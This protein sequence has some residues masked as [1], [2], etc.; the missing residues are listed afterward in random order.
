MLRRPARLI[1]E[2]L[3]SKLNS[4]NEMKKILI[5]FIVF[6]CNQIYAQDYIRYQRIFNRVDEDILSEKYTIAIDRLDSVCE[7][8]SF[9][10]AR[11]CFKAL[12]ICCKSGDSIHAKKW[13]EKVFIQGVPIWMIKVNE[14]TNQIFNYPSLQ[15]T[16]AQY[17]SLRNVYTNSIDQD[18]RTKVDSLIEI[19]Q[20]YTYKINNGFILSRYTYHYPRWLKNNKREQRVLVKLIDRHGFPGEKIIGLPK[21]LEDSAQIVNKF[22]FYGASSLLQE[23]SAY[24]MLIHYYSNPRPDINKRLKE[25]LRLGNIPPYQFG[26]LNDFM[27]EHG[28]KKYG[29][30]KY[31]NVW[32]NDS[33]TTNNPKIEERRNSIG[34]NSLYEQNRNM[35]INRERRK[36]K[37]ANSEIILY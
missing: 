3:G 20:R 33:D 14:L 27:A 22:K 31:Y 11:D 8:Y 16:I 26:G 36:N 7:N 9:I 13:L 2:T 25:N 1:A 21:G 6:S 32:H 35:L 34:L 17:D 4:Q 12:Q 29:N 37:I 18:L 30:Y 19:D 24:T 5:L 28:K 15:N 23:R 10:Y